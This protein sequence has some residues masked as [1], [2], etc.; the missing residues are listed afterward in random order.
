M[1][2]WD[3][4]D[5]GGSAQNTVGEAVS[6]EKP[7]NFPDFGR[8]WPILPDFAEKRPRIYLCS[9]GHPSQHVGFWGLF[10]PARKADAR[11]HVRRGTPIGH[12]GFWGLFG[13]VRKADA[14]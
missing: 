2:T 14:R 8:F 9:R 7:Q 12:V 10:G 11:Q 13:P 3:S 4:E 6:E 5:F 1:N